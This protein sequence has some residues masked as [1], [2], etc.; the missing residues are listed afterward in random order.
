[1]NRLAQILP[2][3][4]IRISLKASSKKRVFEQASLIFE[5]GCN[6][7]RSKIFNSLFSREKLGSTGLG[8][9]IAIPHGRIEGLNKSIAVVLCLDVPIPFDASDGKA[10]DLLIF[11]LVPTSS[12][13]DHLEILA[14]V[15]NMLSDN[16]F[17]DELRYSTS[18]DQLH[19]RICSW[20]QTD[21]KIAD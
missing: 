9:G 8:N 2:K 3:E 20:V 1:M 13:K 12:S 7:A 17:I 4:N 16:K 5:S 15:A 6:I 11:L 18:A 21:S 19:E 14:E 10:V